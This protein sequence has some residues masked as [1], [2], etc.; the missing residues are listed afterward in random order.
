[1]R[2]WDVHDHVQFWM[3]ILGSIFWVLVMFSVDWRV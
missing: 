1:M 3:I 2:E